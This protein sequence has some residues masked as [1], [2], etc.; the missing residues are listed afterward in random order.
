M[1]RAGLWEG[2]HESRRCSR[3]TYPESCI[4][5][6]NSIRK[7]MQTLGCHRA[8]PGQVNFKRLTYRRDFSNSANAGMWYF[9][10][11]FPRIQHFRPPRQGDRDSR[12]LRGSRHLEKESRPCCGS[13]KKDL[14]CLLCDWGLFRDGGLF[15]LG[16]RGDVVLH[17]VLSA[18]HFFP[19]LPG[20]GSKVQ[21]RIG[22]IFPSR[23]M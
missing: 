3:D 8:E 2:Y 21:R 14:C 6:Y 22:I 12:S 16:E 11:Y 17:A 19:V 10:R 20:P 4:I 13:F 7:T 15:E 23:H 5:K 18:R 9:T 1:E